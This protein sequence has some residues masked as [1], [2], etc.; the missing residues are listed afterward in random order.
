MSVLSAVQASVQNCFKR[1]PK[2]KKMAPVNI[3]IRNIS[4][5][6]LELKLVEHFDPPPEDALQM[7]NFTNALSNITNSFGITMNTTRASVPQISPDAQPFASRELSLAIPPFTMVSTDV[8]AV[9]KAPNERFRLTFQTPA[10]GHHQMYCPVPTMESETLTAPPN[11][12]VRF[13]GIYLTQQSFVCLYSSTEPN[14]WMGK[15]PDEIPLGALS[16][17]G[18]HNSPTCHNAPPSVRCQ[19]VSPAEQLKNG[20]RFFDLRVQV[21][22]PYDPNSDVL[23]LVHSVFPISLTGNKYFRDLYKVIT[24]L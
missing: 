8:K 20:V 15:L 2:V 16:I 12:A 11:A 18:T 5:V 17:P 6:P 7:A 4:N 10:G 9:I 1:T 24:D 23:V 14:R 22:T 19:A 21:P 3:T 13:T